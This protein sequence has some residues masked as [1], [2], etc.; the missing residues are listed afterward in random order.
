MNDNGTDQPPD[1][2]DRDE[3]RSEP[4]EHPAG[5]ALV[6]LPVLAKPDTGTRGGVPIG[7]L[8][9]KSRRRLGY[10]TETVARELWL[11]K[12][13]LDNFESGMATP[14][15]DIVERLAEFYGIDPE[16]L[17][18]GRIAERV[19]AP[20]EAGHEILYLAWAAVDLSETDGSNT[21]L[22][23]KLSQTMRSIRGLA[24]GSP[25]SIRDDE[26]EVIASVLDLDHVDFAGDLARAFGLSALE[27]GELAARLQYASK[28]TKELPP[29]PSHREP[30]TE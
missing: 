1:D 10:S 12:R 15:N 28:A 17:T 21:Q 2:A 14:P 19:A 4:R 8:L 20:D 11:S 6:P 5:G 3:G 27:T 18:P 25:V 23:F 7:T 22:L 26:L 13:E 16:R 9:E 29:G 30:E 24:E